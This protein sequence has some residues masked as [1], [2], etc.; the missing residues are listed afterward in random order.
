MRTAL[1]TAICLSA[2]VV[3]AQPTNARVGQLAEVRFER[4]S[5]ELPAVTR[6]QTQQ[7]LGSVAAWAL[8]NPDGT[9]VIDGHA[10]R[11]GTTTANVRLSLQR[12]E[13]VRDELVEEYGI[14]PE[15]IVVA[16]YGKQKDRR[17]VVIWGTRTGLN[18][19]T[20]RTRNRVVPTQVT[21]R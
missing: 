13:T 9:I 10:D 21:Y 3:S 12:A 15:Q 6:E 18:A 20:A 2:G 17:Q 11:T 7:S 16:A 19:V 5:S 4:G 8:E 1:L 14:N